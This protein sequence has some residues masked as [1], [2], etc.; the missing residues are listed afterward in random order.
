MDITRNQ[1]RPR[2]VLSPS[3]V[4]PHVSGLKSGS[5]PCDDL[6]QAAMVVCG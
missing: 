4:V 1:T 2:S 3:A 5:D 6:N